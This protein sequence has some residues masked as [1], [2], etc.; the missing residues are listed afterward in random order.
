MRSQQ[1]RGSKKF[2]GQ[3]TTEEAARLAVAHAAQVAPMG[4]TS[5]TDWSNAVHPGIEDMPLPMNTPQ[6]ILDLGENIPEDIRN[7]VI[8]CDEARQVREELEKLESEAA[9][10]VGPQVLPPI[11]YKMGNYELPRGS[12]QRTTITKKKNNDE[13]NHVYVWGF[14]RRRRY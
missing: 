9:S 8:S 4:S 7:L 13:H 5:G 14:H 10:H 1:R 12:R 3:L 2:G 6:W 11:V